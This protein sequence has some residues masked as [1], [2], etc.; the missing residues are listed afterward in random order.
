MASVKR[1]VKTKRMWGVFNYLDKLCDV[2]EPKFVAEN[3]AETYNKPATIRPVTVTY[4]IPTQA[5][6]RKK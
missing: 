5:K 4:S 2:T 6:R 3:L 1:S